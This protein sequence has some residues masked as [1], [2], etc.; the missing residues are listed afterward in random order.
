MIALLPDKPDRKKKCGTLGGVIRRN[1]LGLGIG[2][3]PIINVKREEGTIIVIN[4]QLIPDWFHLTTITDR[5]GDSLSRRL[6]QW[7]GVI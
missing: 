4:T 1:P 7:A 3:Q 5:M 2:G 6:T